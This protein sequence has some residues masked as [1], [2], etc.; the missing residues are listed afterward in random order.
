[1]QNIFRFWLD[2]E[3]K[4]PWDV[5]CQNPFLFLTGHQMIPKLAHISFVSTCLS[6]QTPIS[7]VFSQHAVFVCSLVD[8]ELLPEATTNRHSIDRNFNLL[9]CK[10]LKN[11]SSVVRVMP[12]F[13]L[14]RI[15]LNSMDRCFSC[16][17]CWH[18]P[19]S[20]LSNFLYAY[21]FP[22]CNECTFSI[23]EAVGCHDV[24]N[25]TSFDIDIIFETRQM[26]N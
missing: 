23:F 1:M 12:F 3:S 9:I 8:Y 14:Q 24:N 21:F 25:L 11:H 18:I 17:N 5:R 26:H 15:K 22:R 6:F 7:M 10:C 16:V 19:N 13:F 4:R 20:W 2:C